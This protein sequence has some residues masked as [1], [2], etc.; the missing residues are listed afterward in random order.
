[1]SGGKDQDWFEWENVRIRYKK[2]NFI[3]KIQWNF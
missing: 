2:L 1:M 3:L